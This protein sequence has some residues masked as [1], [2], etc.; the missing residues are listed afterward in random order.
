ME[1]NLQK[2]IIISLSNKSKKELFIKDIFLNTK[3]LRLT[4]RGKAMMCKYYDHWDFESP[5][6]TAGNTLQ[7]LRKMTY[8]YYYDDKIM[9]LFTERDSFMARLAG[10]Q[11]WLDGKE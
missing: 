1:N 6:K 3:T 8:P 11:G 10:A 9:I 5:G 7:L 2:Q 4:K